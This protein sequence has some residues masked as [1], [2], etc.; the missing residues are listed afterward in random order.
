MTLGIVDELRAAVDPDVNEPFDQ[1]LDAAADEIERLQRRVVVL[2]TVIHEETVP[3]LCN[4]ELNRM[5][6]EDIHNRE[7]SSVSRPN[8]GGET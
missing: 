3:A 1:L 4:S 5:I 8:V 6:V 7:A 2:E